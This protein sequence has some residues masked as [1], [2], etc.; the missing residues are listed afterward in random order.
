MRTHDNGGFV[1]S[2]DGAGV[3]T[4]APVSLRKITFVILG[5]EGTPRVA[6]YETFAR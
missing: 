2:G 6:E 3:I 5:A 4:F 1:A